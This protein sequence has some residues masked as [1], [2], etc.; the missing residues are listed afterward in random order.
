MVCH[1]HDTASK[2]DLEEE[3]TR[4][5]QVEQAYKLFQ[6]A[7][8]YQ[9]L[10]QYD[11]AFKV[12]DELFRLTIISNHYFEEVDFIRGLQNGSQN[13]VPD[14][15]TLMSPN[16]KSLRYLIFRN[17][18]FLY[19]EMLK[20]NTTDSTETKIKDLFYPLLDDFCIALLYNEADEVLLEALY[21]IFT[22]IGADKLLRFTLEYYL[23]SSDE[24]D[25]L[26]GLIPPNKGT[27]LKY[28]NL[29]KA[30]SS[31]KSSQKDLK[32]LH[33]L[34]PI[35]EDI[36]AQ[37]RKINAIN[38]RTITCSSMKW[39]GLLDAVNHHLKE[40]QDEN[41]IED[42][43]RPRIK[44]IEPYI[45]AEDPIDRVLV[46]FVKKEH[47][48]VVEIPVE[49]EVV[50]PEPGPVNE[51]K[52]QEEENRIHRTSKR[53][54][55]V[56][57]EI[58][59]VKLE[60][61]HF[62]NMNIFREKLRLIVPQLDFLDVSSQYVNKSESSAQYLTDFSDLLA[63]WN[64]ST[65]ANFL[66]FDGD[67]SGD[68]N[69][70]LL[71]LL[72]S[73]GSNEENIDENVPV[74]SEI[75]IELPEVSYFEFKTF[76]IKHL[77][78]KI[79]S[80]KW[81]GKLYSK[82]TEWVVQFE[83]YLYKK[84]DVETAVGVLEVL[85]DESISLELNIKDYIETKFNKAVV[86]G[87]CQDLLR[88]NDK[89][90]RWVSF[91]Q[92][93]PINDDK[94][95]LFRF[96]WCQIIKEKSQTESWSENYSLRQKFENLLNIVDRKISYPN[97]ANFIEL[98]KDSIGNQLTMIS[99]LAIFWKILNTKS[100]DDNTDAIELLESILIDKSKNDNPAIESIKKFLTQSSI[101]MRL[102]LWNILLSFYISGKLG[103]KL[104]LGFQECVNFLNEYLV[105]D[106]ALLSEPERIPSLSKV[107]GFYGNCVSMMVKQLSE[108]NWILEETI[109]LESLTKFFEIFLLFEINEEAAYLS[110]LATSIKVKS[111]K[112]YHLLTNTLLKSIVLI[113]ACIKKHKSA[114][115]LHNSIKLFHIQLGLIGV[116][117]DADGAFLE[118]CQE[119]LKDLPNSDNDI[120]QIIKCK[121]HYTISLEGF[122][123]LDHDT[124]R[125]EELNKSDCEELTQFV[126]PLCFSKGNTI[127]NVPKH[128]IK[129]LIDEIYEVV[130][131]PDFESNDALSR[132]KASLQSFLDSTKL[133]TRLFKDAFHG[134]IDFEVEK[135]DSKMINN[136]LY[137]IEGLLIFSGYKSRKK[138]MQSR[139]VEVENAITLF[140]NDLIYGSNRFESWFLLGQ[141]YGYLVED[142]LI[143]T[144]DKLT[145]ADR[146]IA[147]ANL[148]RKSLICYLMAINKTL[149]ESIRGS[150]KE[151]IGNLM[152]SFAKEMF[153]AV[154]EPMNMHALKVQAHPR[155]VNRTI[156]GATFES[157][158]TQP[159]TSKEVCMKIIQ[160]SLHIAIKSKSRDWSDY[161]YL[162]KVQ[163][164][165][166][167]PAVLVMDTMVKAC[168]H[169]FKYRQA[170]NIVEPHYALVSLAYKYVKDSKLP[171]T[172]AVKYL[173]NDPLVHLDIAGETDFRKV[174]IKALKKVDGSD[175]KKWQHKSKYRMAVILREQF[176]D[177]KGA[178]E[179]MSTFISLK[180]TS[181]TLVSIWKPEP[182][183]PGKHFL[184]TYQYIYFYIE[185]LKE[186]DDL[187]SLVTMLPKL[188]RSNSVMIN[189]P[190]VWEFLCSSICKIIREALGITNTFEFTENLINTLSYQVFSV[191]VK[192]MLKKMEGQPMAEDLK[193]H[194]CFLYAINDMKKANN[195]YG[196]TSFIDD[197][198]VATYF[199]IYLYYNK[200]SSSME[201]V[202]TDSPGAK[203]KIA[204]RDIFPLTNDLMK[205][206][207]TQLD[208]LLKKDLYND[209]VV[210]EKWKR[211][212]GSMTQEELQAHLQKEEEQKRIQEE[213]SKQ[214]SVDEPKIKEEKDG[215]VKLDGESKPASRYEIIVLEDDDDSS[216]SN[217][218]NEPS[219]K[220]QKT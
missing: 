59:E 137:Y 161:Y 50:N 27:V 73:Y 168:E 95:L 78:S 152:S 104:A 74:L 116:C 30:L 172:E 11:T 132:N 6:D 40:M 66:S 219:L 193:P 113:V 218:T 135:I 9:K 141:A 199:H 80:T 171:G 211:K 170:D 175:T 108:S 117:D 84:V 128:D 81:E 148:Q 196:P 181:K 209:F 155:F 212:V 146:K 190:V 109:S 64:E 194:L 111:V 188:R 151:I 115:A 131:D 140:E 174:I 156:G 187:N 69:S 142:D 32:H 53:L 46:K 57:S 90:K 3:H 54:L 79:M 220:K 167:K 63:N 197:T 42:I 65:T 163:R 129:M 44:A 136:G 176:G 47:H 112:S 215:E 121:Y 186:A 208:E 16:V 98:S 29:L 14:E 13:T 77:I 145:G 124:E 94:D 34:E 107:L 60:V 204:K 18:G 105:G 39:S 85:I 189:L 114:D 127:N 100:K 86:N 72:S 4:E 217:D 123:P 99:V 102:N 55:K 7:L 179:L 139:A 169:A 133:T 33:F 26:A 205:V 36:L 37:Q 165:M 143:W 203:K 25:D 97:Y 5:L 154:F 126:I 159:A 67:K 87:M 162:A 20:N 166:G 157:V 28:N 41:K 12:Y 119:Y 71:D 198:L 147:T 43:Y 202:T 17:R 200:D 183:R 10:K 76:I 177:V 106:Y 206:Y 144:S 88:L 178:T 21:D 160:Q 56:E 58:P 185:L 164:K 103:S 68:D 8:K 101:D 138:N 207:K 180:A 173:V 91:V 150:I 92:D 70:R 96:H 82:F 45:L 35:K 149:D 1:L 214:Q 134:L 22:Y 191:N 2:K 130:G 158:S 52:K 49:P 195:G 24:S 153:S 110:S 192:S 51:V 48:T 23:T 83:N 122:T 120:C 213:K 125:I 118:I 89:I 31:G 216:S 93:L 38:I 62:V 61:S 201:I 19:L 75:D 184:Y 15:L 210:A 182:E